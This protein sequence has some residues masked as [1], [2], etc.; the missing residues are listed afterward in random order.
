MPEPIQPTPIAETG[1]PQASQLAMPVWLLVLMFLLLYWGMVYFDQHSG[2]FNTEVY[3]PYYSLAEVQEFQ[4]PTGG[5]DLQRGKALFDNVCALCHNPDGMGKPG[6]APPFVGSEWVVGPPS[7]LIRIPLV[8]LTGPVSVKGQ[9]FTFAASMPPMGASFSNDDLAAVL[10]YMR[11]S[12]GNK[13]PPV[14]SDEVKAVRAQI[15]NRAQ[16]WTPQELMQIPAK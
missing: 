9:V 13:A 4:P 2:W 12:W 14:T 15:G 3:V 6:Q 10:S 5:V 11:Q 16:P 1:E 7:R 8:G